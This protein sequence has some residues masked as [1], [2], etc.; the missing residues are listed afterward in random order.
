MM[1]MKTA[2]LPGPA[3]SRARP[4]GHKRL[5]PICRSIVYQGKFGPF[6]IGPEDER[7]VFLYRAGINVAMLGKCTTM[8]A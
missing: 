8:H 7:E 4:I 3:L 6:T 1:L 2:A 5:G